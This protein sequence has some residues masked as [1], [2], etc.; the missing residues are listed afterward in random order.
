VAAPV[1]RG[2]AGLGVVRS[3]SWIVTMQIG[4]FLGYTS[5]GYLGDRFGR[6]PVFLTFVLGAAAVVPVY[7][8]SARSPE[9]LFA[10]GP[11]VGFFG[12]GYFSVFGALLAELFPSSVRATA[13]GLCYNTGR[14][15]S[16]LAPT[17]IGYAADRSGI[18]SALGI[19][20]GFFVAS[21]LLMLLL[22]ETKGQELE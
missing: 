16:A 6:K 21:A 11:L 22:P 12:H 4:S 2:G 1:E 3:T 15:M 8:N 5:F 18:G 7:G 17:A 19:T 14:A 9:L 20:S 10:L 13:Q